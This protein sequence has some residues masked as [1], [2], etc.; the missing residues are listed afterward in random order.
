L[1]WPYQ[2]K[3]ARESERCSWRG[4][5][6]NTSVRGCPGSAQYVSVW[7]GAPNSSEG[8]TDATVSRS[9]CTSVSWQS[10]A[11]ASASVG[12]LGLDFSGG[13]EATRDELQETPKTW[14]NPRICARS[15]ITCRD[16]GTGP[17]PRGAS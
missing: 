6:R 8:I 2:F 1:Q 14:K 12:N 17:C 3:L 16:H 4:G 5:N 11:I 7:G 15:R 13:Q 10:T 9:S